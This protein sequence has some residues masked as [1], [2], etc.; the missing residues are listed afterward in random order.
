LLAAGTG[1]R[2]P[3]KTANPTSIDHHYESLRIDVRSL[4]TALGIAA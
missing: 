3:P 4:F 1:P 2:S